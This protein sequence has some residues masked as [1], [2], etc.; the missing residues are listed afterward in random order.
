MLPLILKY[1][2]STLRNK[3]IPDSLKS[4]LEAIIQLNMSLSFGI[5]IVNIRPMKRQCMLLEAILVY[6]ELIDHRCIIDTSSIDHRWIIDW[7]SSIDQEYM[8]MDML[9]IIMIII[10]IIILIMVVDMLINNRSNTTHIHG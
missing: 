10:S 8:F 5:H 7:S 9:V 6:E 4:C 1:V 3:Q 2:L